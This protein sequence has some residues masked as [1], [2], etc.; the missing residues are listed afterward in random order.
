MLVETAL[1]H[2]AMVANQVSIVGTTEPIAE[3]TIASEVSGIVERFPVNEGDYVKKGAVLAQLRAAELEY[4]I[5]SAMASRDKIKTGIT[6][7]EKELNRIKRLKGSDSISEKKYD[8]TVYQYEAMLQDLVKSEAEISRLM[9]QKRQTKVLAPFS[10]FV[11]EEHTQVGE[12]VHT[13]G[14]VVTLIDLG[15][16]YVTVDVPERYASMLAKGAKARVKV[17]SASDKDYPGTVYAIVPQGN[18]KSRTFAAKIRISNPGLSIKGGMEA[19]A[20][21]NLSGQ[22]EALLA[23]K[24]AVVSSGDDKVVYTVQDGK[25]MPV[26]VNI[27]GYHEGS[28]VVDG[29]LKDGDPVVIRGNERLRPGFPVVV[30]DQ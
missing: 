8:D 28:V 2:K 3:S 20:A 10:G 16:I 7:A 5:N 1:V 29:N 21:F 27:L 24:D 12:W 15:E 30:A 19:L 17:K 13:G 22:R 4:R 6:V 26:S 9:Y 23:P 18:V 25:A 14:S 11:S